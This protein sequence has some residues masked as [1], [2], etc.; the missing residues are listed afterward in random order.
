F[1]FGRVY[2]GHG[3]TYR[4]IAVAVLSG[5]VAWA[6]ER[7]SLLL[8]TLVSGALLMLM[9]GWLVFPE[10]L[11]F[12]LPTMETLREM[13]KAASAVG[14]EARVQISPAPATRALLFAGITAVWAA[15]F[16]CH[17]LAFRAGSPLLGL[18]PPVALVAFADSVLDDFD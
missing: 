17:A 6:F 16:S 2:V 3:V 5:V 12:G 11:R 4:L 14:E 13:G 18:V 9:L 7:R 8:A 10:S 15:V 1:A